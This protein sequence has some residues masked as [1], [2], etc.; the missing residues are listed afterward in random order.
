MKELFSDTFR[1]SSYY[2]LLKKPINELYFM[3]EKTH[4][5]LDIVL[6]DRILNHCVVVEKDDHLFVTNILSYSEHD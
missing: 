3:L 6:T 1:I 2:H 5:Q 4:C